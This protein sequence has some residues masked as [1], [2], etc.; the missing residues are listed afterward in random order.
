MKQLKVQ[1]QVRLSPGRIFGLTISG[2]SVRMF[3]SLVTVVILTLAVTFLC[4]SLVHSL[5][6]HE[7]RYYAD[8]EL[9]RYRVPSRW[10][11][12]VTTP[13][14]RA[15]IRQHLAGRTEPY[16]NEYRR[17]AGASAARMADA[18]NAASRLAAYEAYFEQLSEAK[19]LILLQGRPPVDALHA[20]S[21]PNER[22]RLRG[23]LKRLTVPDPPGGLEAMVNFARHDLRSVIDL[24]D[25]IRAG[26]RA[27]I[28]QVAAVRGELIPMRWFA[29]A[30]SPI[31]TTLSRAGF[32][33]DAEIAERLHEAGKIH[34]AQQAAKVALNVPAMSKKLVR[35]LDVE[36]IEL[37][38]DRL[39][40]WLDDERRA[41]WMVEQMRQHMADDAD[42]R[43]PTAQTLAAA[44]AQYRRQARLQDAVGAG[45][46]EA[47]AG[48][49]DLP[50]NTQWLI[51]LSFLVCAVGVTN[52]MFMS[53]TER[54]AEIATMKCLGALD[55]FLMQMFLFESLMQGLVGA[56]AGV[57][58]GLAIALGRGLAAYGAMAWTPMP[59]PDI[60]LG[61]VLSFIV[62]LVLS[63]IAGVGPALAVARLAPME[64]MRIE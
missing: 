51:T 13:D 5:V 4:H 42:V 24:V 25:R 37:H 36:V 44:A 45:T 56:T 41:R 48:L 60:V 2:I 15:A 7:A 64:A 34:T 29:Q 22:D 53:V 46:V 63:V 43:I 35:T 57:V 33:A 23:N 58:L 8:Q 55:G 1:N 31:D 26:H 30:D 6:S 14:S 62:G 16:F 21:D 17:W 52:A 9:E 38:Q 20:L 3:R 54:F 40:R 59:W 28:E 47:R 50:I 18:A 39:M 10:A 27:A 12:R 49:F 32:A 61:G 19:A 11:T